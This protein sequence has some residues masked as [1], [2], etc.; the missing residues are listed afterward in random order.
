MANAEQPLSLPLLS[1]D[2]SYYSIIKGIVSHS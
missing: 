2:F 1:A